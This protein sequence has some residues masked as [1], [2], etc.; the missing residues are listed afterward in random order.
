MKLNPKAPSHDFH[1][2]NKNLSGNDD[3]IE[4]FECKKLLVLFI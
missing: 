1:L 3:N 2:Q 4:E